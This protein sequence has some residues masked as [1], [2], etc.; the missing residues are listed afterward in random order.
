MRNFNTMRHL[1]PTLLSASTSS[2]FRMLSLCLCLFAFS[3]QSLALDNNSNEHVSV[4]T[5]DEDCHPTVTINND[6]P[7]PIAVYHWT[8]KG[9]IYLGTVQKFSDASFNDVPHGSKY[10]F[11]NPNPNWHNL[12]Y[13]EHHM[14]NSCSNYSID[15]ST[16]YCGVCQAN[17]TVRNNGN[18][19]TCIYR[20]LPSGDVPLTTLQPGHSYTISGAYDCDKYRATD[21]GPWNNLSF[22]ESFMKSGCSNQ[23]WNLSPNYCGAAL[24]PD[25][26]CGSCNSE[27]VFDG[28]IELVNGSYEGACKMLCG[29]KPETSL[30]SLPSAFHNG[31][32]N[33]KI[34]QYVSADGYTN[35]ANANQTCERWK[36]EF[37][38]N[39]QKVGETNATQDV[40]DGQ[41]YQW[42]TG[43]LN[44]TYLSD[45]ATH[46]K[47]VHTGCNCGGAQSVFVSGVC[48]CKEDLT[49]ECEITCPANVTIDCDES[50]DPSNTG[51]ATASGNNCNN[52]TITY[53]DDYN[54]NNCPQTITRTWTATGQQTSST[55]FPELVAHWDFGNIPTCNSPLSN[56]GVSASMVNHLSCANVHTSKVTGADDGSSCVQG[57]FGTPETAV[58]VQ[59]QDDSSWSD[60]N[61]DAV[62]FDI[63]FNS[64]QSGALTEFCFYERVTT[65]NENFGHTAYPEKWGFRV[66]KNGQE[67]FQNINN[68]T[69][70]HWTQHCFDFSGNSAFEYNGNTVFRFELLGYDPSSTSNKLRVIWELDDFKVYACC[71]NTTSTPIVETCT[72]T[73]TVCR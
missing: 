11:V 36:I 24:P 34:P 68:G 16:N 21:C 29:S 26:V 22:D 60:N 50:A 17:I 1:I 28:D 65:S 33:V 38:K 23:T 19:E 6:G 59:D 54:G 55:C 61:D 51:T 32:M 20:W 42:I 13:D 39:G 53:H 7:C 31:M 72:Q 73:I 12:L 63:T 8:N 35:R 9:D 25:P 57:A 3:N 37:Y 18:C 70:F 40:P 58:C 2:C 43:S 48:F 46:F 62:H 49:P 52:P 10:R 71:A 45:G 15:L 5:A 27:F 4:E 67:I 30:I 41:D 64:S 56:G 14:V 66:L 69:S 44:D 47:A